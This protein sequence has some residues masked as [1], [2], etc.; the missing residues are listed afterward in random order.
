MAQVVVKVNCWPSEIISAC[1]TRPTSKG[2]GAYIGLVAPVK[3][4]ITES[5]Q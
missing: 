4:K 1:R 5:S 2:S 3:S